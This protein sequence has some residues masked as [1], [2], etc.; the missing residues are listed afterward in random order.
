MVAYTQKI[1]M[2]A[3]ALVLI[4]LSAVSGYGGINEKGNSN[5]VSNINI[6]LITGD[7][8]A[9][10]NISGNVTYSI[11]PAKTGM[12]RTYQIMVSPQGTYFI[13]NNVD[14]KKVDMELFNVEY[15][16]K[17]DYTNLSFIP[18][19]MTL[20]SNP[21]AKNGID[22]QEIAGIDKHIKII[23]THKKIGVTVARLD[24]KDTG[25]AFDTLL[26]NKDVKK[27]WLDKKRHISLSD[28]VP[29]L[30]APVIWEQGY[31][32]SGIKIAILDTG[33]DA[34]HPDLNDIDDNPLTNDPKVIF[35]NN[36]VDWTYSDI[37]DDTIAD[38]YGHG[39][40]VA[41]IAAG[42]GE[43][44]GGLYKGVAPGAYLWNLRVLN[45][46][47]SG[48]DS[49]IIGGINYAAY[50]P[51]GIPR[52]GDEADIISMSLGGG[53]TEGDD[54]MSIAVNSAIDAGVVVTIAAGNCGNFCISTP[55]AA[56]KV[57]TVGATD[58]SDYLAYFSSTGPTLDFRVKPDVVAPGVNIVAARASGTSMGS[59]LNSYY[60]SESGTSMATPHVA[61]AAA[62]IL[63]KAKESIPN[64]ILEPPQYYNAFPASYNWID[65]ITG[66]TPG[67][68]YGDD[69]ATSAID[70]GFNFTF[71]GKNYSRLY[72]STN[73]LIT[74]DN[75]IPF[76][77]NVPI[78]SP[79]QP[80]NFIAPFWDDL[81]V[82]NGTGNTYYKL[83]ASSN[84]KK[85]IITWKDIYRLGY[86]NPVTFQ[87]VLFSNGSFLFQY[88]NISNIGY[89]DQTIGAENTDGGEGIQYGYA[90]PVANLSAV[91]FTPKISGLGKPNYVKNALI[92]TAKDLSLSVYE[93]GG[94]RV[95]IPNAT[96]ARIIADPASVSF[97]IITGI[98]TTVI[99]FYN[100][101]TT[102]SRTLN[103]DEVVRDSSGNIVNAASLN[104]SFLIIAPNST[105]SVILTVDA[106]SIPKSTY[107]GKLTAIADNGEEVGVIFGFANLN[108][109]N[110]N[111]IKFD[112]TPAAYELVWVYET[113]AISPYPLSRFVSTDFNGMAKVLVPDGEYNIWSGSFFNDIWIWTTKDELS[114]TSD[115]STTLDERDSV[116]VSFDP[117]KPDQTFA[118]LY[119]MLDYYRYS[120]SLL[121]SNPSNTTVRIT[122]TSVN[123]A[124]SYEYYPAEDYNS[125][126]PS[127]INTPEWQKLYF[128]EQGISS[129]KNYIAD[130]SKLVRRTGIY[131]TALIN[132]SAGRHE[133][134]M[135]KSYLACICWAMGW[136]M[137]LPQQRIEYITPDTYYWGGLSSQNWS[138]SNWEYRSYPHASTP[139]D[140]WNAQP[141]SWSHTL[142]RGLKLA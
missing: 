43:A 32:G 64:W 59:P 115:T 31:N 12:N 123:I 120:W 98:N 137:D 40:H 74:F 21:N 69:V 122:P 34:A 96:R 110:I 92:S 17:E 4:L 23:S 124:H 62:L 93:Q 39:T 85:F 111:K 106:T 134:A 132:E 20:E 97:K 60:T 130:Y 128:S 107:S 30:G 142:N 27:V 81:N 50:G 103:L 65:G 57:I 7:T 76:F 5:N 112:G 49:W 118:G 141:F 109:L 136:Q 70:I 3:I 22:A 135:N 68:I 119:S 41:S 29:M 38:L 133:W 86:S 129:P 79:I 61:G 24:K 89:F 116:Q 47:G 82:V 46:Y 54:P 51:D 6:T 90:S 42:T 11:L 75:S 73:G 55:G 121:Y 53:P 8:V 131:K 28:S 36:F 67:G 19:M 9:A 66:G 91:M 114:V 125:S 58:K 71:Y 140:F 105:A 15:L 48:Y 77:S 25:P 84:P 108:E 72:F 18:V 139:T 95:R 83:D 87:A 44:S 26:A 14:L 63:Q 104:T 45:K 52:T 16:L 126:D 80:N 2:G 37:S 78:P 35:H 127:R 99:T 13:P 117:N 10:Y 101:N 56:D 88:K 1:S 100:L 94:G 138:L 33:I 102:S 113:N